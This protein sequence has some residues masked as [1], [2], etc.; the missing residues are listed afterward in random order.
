MINSI[1]IFT[2]EDFKHDDCD[3]ISHNVLEETGM[4]V[5]VMQTLVKELIS[6]EQVIVN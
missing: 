6:N 2:A 1:G 4:F 5:S 3:E